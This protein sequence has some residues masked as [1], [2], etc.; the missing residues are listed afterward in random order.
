MPLW[1]THSY[2][3]ENIVEAINNGKIDFIINTTFGKQAIKDS[4]SL[5]RASLTKNLTYCTTMAGALALV[6]GLRTLGQK[7]MDV[8]TLQE[9]RDE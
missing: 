2:E 4:F 6:N 8:V 5:R 9:Y 7:E 1:C 3:A